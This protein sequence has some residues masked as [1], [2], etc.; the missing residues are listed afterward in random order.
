MVPAYISTFI[1][2]FQ[3]MAVIVIL[4]Y[5]VTRT[6]SF[7]EVLSGVFTWKNQLF[8]I[9][10]FGIMSIYGTESGILILGAPVNVR[11]LGPMVGGLACGPVVGIGAG[12]IGAAYRFTL[13]GFTEM[14]CSLATFLAGLLAGLIYLANRRTFVGWKI[15]VVF[16]VVMESLHMALVLLLSR[17]YT[18]AVELVSLVAAPMILANAAGMFI[19]AVIIGNLITER[20]TKTER[21]MYELEL[22]REKAELEVAREIQVSLI[23]EI[24][25]HIPGVELAARSIPAKV[26]GGDFYDVLQLPDQKTGLIIADVSGKGMPAAL[27]M[28]LS[29]TVVRANATWHAAAAD[30]IQ[31]ANM[32]IAEDTRSGMF[33]TLFY[34]IFNART[35]NLTYV[36]AGHNPPLL[37]R[38]LKQYEELR[39]TGMALGVLEDSRF[40]EKTVQLNPGDML[41]I[42]TDGVTE[43]INAQDEQYGIER[44][45]AAVQSMPGRSATEVLDTIIDQVNQFSGQAPQYDDITLMVL[46][47]IPT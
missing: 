29:R 19:F 32:M 46:R 37:F 9:V 38:G 35:H 27:F 43:A 10:F 7:S 25:P 41:L 34:G 36:N 1:V 30:A 8:L 16:A 24:L 20:K 31:D 42:Y 18:E 13:G 45:M 17:P 33:V 28:G 21:D 22:E 3:M 6:R 26:V 5:L 40:E 44:L 11:D 23:P 12:L 4:A 14:A 15:A 47:V 2:L 39:G